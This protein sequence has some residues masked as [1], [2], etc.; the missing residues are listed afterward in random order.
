ML[1]LYQPHISRFWKIYFNSLQ[2]NLV[3]SM[4]WG[5][6]CNNS[7]MPFFKPKNTF[8]TS[9]NAIFNI[10]TYTH[11]FCTF[12]KKPPKNWYTGKQPTHFAMKP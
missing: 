6:Q 4:F 11:S 3:S 1:R 9:I 8:F 2:A 7:L 5:Y 10:I 12:N